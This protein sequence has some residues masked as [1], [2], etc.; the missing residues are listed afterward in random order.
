MQRR[1]ASRTAEYM[2][3]FRALEFAQPA[4]RRLFEDRFAR[5][6][7]RPRLRFVVGLAR[8]PLM[9]RSVPALIDHRWPGART[10][11]VARTRFIDEVVE[12]TLG[13][14][15]EQVV[16]LG[17]GFD[18]RAY[19]IA[20]MAKATVFEV[21]HPAT[22]TAKRR[23]VG[24]ALGAVP[25]HV[26][27]VTLDFNTEPLPNTMSAAGFDPT[28]RTLFVWEG[29]TNYLVEEAVEVTLR[30]C[31][32]AAGGSA[33]VF[34]YVDRHVL[35]APE[36][37]AGTPSSLRR[38]GN[39]ANAG[40]SGSILRT[41]PASWRS[42]AWCSTRISVPSTTEVATLAGR[43]VTCEVTS[44]IASPSPTCPGAMFGNRKRGQSGRGGKGKW[45]ATNSMLRHLTFRST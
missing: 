7:L 27:F 28:R 21:D 39:R 24:A 18:A 44:S 2:A 34:T 5:A 11:G 33:V 25:R 29:V 37:F 9:G 4:E 42:A 23:L 19:R 36:A 40:R 43:R 10:S 1:E 6:F 32:S 38:L 31:A 17:A 41:W 15:T 45:L 16:L 26:H 13:V 3:L 12:A 8:L 30:W 20:A 35:D 14:G 22:S